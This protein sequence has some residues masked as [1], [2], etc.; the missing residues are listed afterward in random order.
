MSKKRFIIKVT[1]NW[2]G[3]DN[4]YP[5]LAEKESDLWEVADQL[6]IDNLYAY[7]SQ[8]ELA[9]ECCIY[10]DNYKDPDEYQSDVDSINPEDYVNATIELFTRGDVDWQC[11]VNDNHG[12]IIE[13]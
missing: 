8:E 5:A 11:L 12:E 7:M 13:V 10:E 1:T 4:D 9:E 2:C 3:M 6:A